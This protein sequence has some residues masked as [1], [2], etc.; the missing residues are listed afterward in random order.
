MSRGL[1]TVLSSSIIPCSARNQYR[2]SVDHVFRSLGH[3]SL[4]ES[5]FSRSP[6]RVIAQSSPHFLGPPITISGLSAMRGPVADSPE[7]GRSRSSQKPSAFHIYLITS[8]SFRG[9]GASR[10]QDTQAHFNQYALISRA[11]VET[12]VAMSLKRSC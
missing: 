9:T 4:S 12:A 8:K 7:L 3:Q 2:L 6:G 1:P 5:N 11:R 10:T